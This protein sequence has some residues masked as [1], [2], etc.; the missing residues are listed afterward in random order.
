MA[1]NHLCQSL[2]FGGANPHQ[3]SAGGN[4]A[5]VEVELAALEVSD[6]LRTQRVAKAGK[7]ADRDHAVLAG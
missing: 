6:C 1:N 2:T 4:V 7:D 3:V 5:H